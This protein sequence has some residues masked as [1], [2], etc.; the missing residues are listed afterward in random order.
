MSLAK[1]ENDEDIIKEKKGNKT[2]KNL[3]INNKNK[4][5]EINNIDKINTIKNN[6]EINE[7]NFD[8]IKEHPK[9]KFSDM[10]T[11]NSLQIKKE[12]NGD[13]LKDGLDNEF[14]DKE[15]FQ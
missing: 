12:F 2:S 3:E 6:N 14:L 4:D 7:N 11:I 13:F 8:N 9:K 1:E 15:S 5:L 10:D